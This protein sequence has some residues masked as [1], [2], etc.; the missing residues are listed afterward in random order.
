ME[1]ENLI[2][3]YDDVRLKLKIIK[4]MF[5]YLENTLSRSIQTNTEIDVDQIGGREREA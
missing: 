4:K 1:I 2:Q 3:K 5:F